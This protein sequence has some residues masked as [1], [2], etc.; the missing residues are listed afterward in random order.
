MSEISGYVKNMSI[1]WTH[2]MKRSVGPGQTIPLSEL[3]EQ[4]GKKH[5][6]EPGSEFVSWLLDVKL[7][8]RNKW[9]VFNEDDTPMEFGQ[10]KKPEPKTEPAPEKPKDDR[11]APFVSKGMEIADV[12]GLSVRQAREVVP[13]ITDLNLLRY[14]VKEANQL[15]GKDS[16]CRILRKR[17]SELEVTRRR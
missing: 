17:I 5:D 11:N 7:K 4:Y 9:R 10:V 16:L 6:L 3:Y 15:A 13:K 12:V 2:A 1:N 14:A 8:D